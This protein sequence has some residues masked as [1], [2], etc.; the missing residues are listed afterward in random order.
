LNKEFDIINIV[1][2]SKAKDQFKSLF[3]EI[4]VLDSSDEADWKTSLAQKVKLLKPK[5]LYDCVGGKMA[6]RLVHSIPFGSHI[7]VFGSES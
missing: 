6:Q 4:V 3:P 1:R 7:V 2:S 5:A